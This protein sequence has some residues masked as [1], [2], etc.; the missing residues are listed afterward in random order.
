MRR[1]PAPVLPCAPSRMARSRLEQA[2]L[3]PAGLCRRHAVI[4]QG[5]RR[6]GCRASGRVPDTGRSMEKRGLRNLYLSAGAQVPDE[7]KVIDETVSGAPV[8]APSVLGRHRPGGSA[9][10]CSPVRFAAYSRVIYLSCSLTSRKCTTGVTMSERS[11]E[12]H[13]APMTA[14][15][16]GCSICAPAPAP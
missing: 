4:G 15:P 1:L 3:D 5:V 13:S 8:P 7:A 14:T 10:P 9:P 2:S 16:R 12:K 6:D 11:T